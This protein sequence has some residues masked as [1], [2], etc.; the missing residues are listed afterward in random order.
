MMKFIFIGFGLGVAFGAFVCMAVMR[1]KPAKKGV[2]LEFASKSIVIDANVLMD[3][4]G[5]H[6]PKDTIPF[7]YKYPMEEESIYSK[8]QI[9]S[10][11][12]LKVGIEFK[13]TAYKEGFTF[14]DDR[15]VKATLLKWT[16][17]GK[18][19]GVDTYRWR[20]NWEYAGVSSLGWT[21]DCWIDLYTG[22]AYYD[23]KN[24]KIVYYDTAPTT[25]P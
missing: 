3:S 4:S 10:F 13:P 19:F 12:K 24:M 1:N 5:I 14:Y 6:P 7:K 18:M 20:T 9:D 11:N 8:E 16:Y 15:G 2:T 23:K 17:N 21:D 22:K 25:I